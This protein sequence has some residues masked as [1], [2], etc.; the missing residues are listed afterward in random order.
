MS[1]LCFFCHWSLC[2]QTRHVDVLL[3]LLTTI[4]SVSKVDVDIC[5]QRHCDFHK[6]SFLA[7]QGNEACFDCDSNGTIC[8]Q[9]AEVLTETSPNS[10]VAATRGAS[11][12]PRG[13][14][15]GQTRPETP[16]CLAWRWNDW[17]ACSTRRNPK[18]GGSAPCLPRQQA[19]RHL[20]APP[21]GRKRG[22]K[23]Q[24]PLTGR[25]P[26]GAK[27]HDPWTG[28]S[29]TGDGRNSKLHPGINPVRENRKGTGVQTLEAEHLTSSFPVMNVSDPDLC[30]RSQC[31]GQDKGRTLTT[32]KR[33]CTKT[34]KWR[35][36]SQGGCPRSKNDEGGREMMI[37]RRMRVWRMEWHGM[38]R[39]HASQITVIV[40]LNVECSGYVVCVCVYVCGRYAGMCV[41]VG[42]CMCIRKCVW[43]WEEREKENLKTLFYKACSLGSVKTSLTTSPC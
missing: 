17:A 16:L 2:N 22:A 43:E 39:R 41:C 7:A 24:A 10:P 1:V 21:P 14:R 5:W 19:L 37:M 27:G 29:R 42:M 40:Q 25:G 9:M 33:R 12:A 32:T 11:L 3:I 31:G 15:D 38:K 8:P 23:W 13:R 36:E 20:T 35:S 6:V 34:M 28:R 18:Q 26:T 30:G 4:P